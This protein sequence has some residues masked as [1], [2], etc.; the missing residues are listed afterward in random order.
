MKKI[1]YAIERGRNI[2]QYQ[3]GNLK[4]FEVEIYNSNV[5]EAVKNNTSHFIYADHWADSQIQDVRA[6]NEVEALSLINIRY[7]HDKG[8]IIEKITELSEDLF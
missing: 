6:C 1:F 2:L 5:R 8:F 4:S 3:T 7:P